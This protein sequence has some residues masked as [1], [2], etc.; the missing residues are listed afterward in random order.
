M[1]RRI[2]SM[3]LATAMVVTS[4]AGLGAQSRFHT[5]AR[6]PS[7]TFMPPQPASQALPAPRSKLSQAAKALEQATAEKLVTVNAPPAAIDCE[8]VRQAGQGI[9][10]KIR[11]ST[12]PTTAP[13]SGGVVTMPSCAKK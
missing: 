9:D 5:G 10:P 13:V 2:L 6:F 1:R 8:M 12:S 4:G 11:K 3:T 7:M